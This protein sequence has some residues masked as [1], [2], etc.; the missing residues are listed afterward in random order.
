ME[1]N[2]IQEKVKP[3]H[4]I[5]V[6][7]LTA[8]IWFRPLQIEAAPEDYISNG[9][10]ALYSETINGILLAHYIFQD[11]IAYHP[12]DP[13]INAYLALTRLL[14]L[15]LKSG[16]G[17]LQE[18]LTSYGIV[19]TGSD[20]DTLDYHLPTDGNGKYNVPVTAPRT[21]SVRAFMS[22]VLLSAID[23][24]IGNLDTTI[25]NWTDTSKHIVVKEKR[26]TD[27]DTEVDY[28][29]IYLFRA[30]LKGLKSLVLTITAYD[31]N[32]DI[33]EIA[34]LENLEA[35]SEKN[36]LDRYLYFLNLLPTSATPTGNGINQLAPA[37][38]ILMDGIDDY[39]AASQKIRNDNDHTAGADE[40]F[41]INECDYILEEW[42][43]DSL[44]S[45]KNTLSNPSNPA[46]EIPDQ[47]EEWIFTDLGT[48]HNIRVFMKHN[49]SE[50]KFEGLNSNDFVGEDGDIA[51]LTINGDQIYIE[52]ESSG[53]PYYEVAFSGT[54]NGTSDSINDGT[55]DG[56]SVLGPVSGSFAATRVSFLANIERINLNPFFGNGSG[57]YDARDFLPE[58]NVCDEPVPATVGIGLNPST[59]D[60]TLGGILPDYI[61][62]DWGLDPE[63]CSTLGTSVTGALSVP[64]HNGEGLIYIQ[65]FSYTGQ[66]NT[67]PDNRL[68]FQVIYA[69]EFIEGM[70][71]SLDYLPVGVQVFVTAWWDVDLNGILW[72]EDYW[73]RFSAFTT[74]SGQTDLNL[75]LNR[76]FGQ[77]EIL[78]GINFLLLG[79]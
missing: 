48:G 13:V 1:A 26:G 35:F 78:P 42:F 59:P 24:S 9:E 43:R 5:L 16:S 2:L 52:M 38:T 7:F 6:I 50:G 61:Q 49:K 19:R 56:W 60:A 23:A 8:L 37:R 73:K 21:E 58:F 4:Y 44:T 20:L 12:N 17:G 77:T 34:A 64:K 79:Y 75:T 22:G 32:V 45:I 18:L 53:Y 51:C 74:Q 15:A 39:I 62:D 29:D 57:P 55:Y 30:G 72:F 47:E 27:M 70:T 66:Y 68:G 28:G 41:E 33:R 36:F 25:A 71:Y 69:D 76:K 40:L 3:T 67:D 54:L 65:L 10:D 46:S 14:D 11:A 31:L 63:S